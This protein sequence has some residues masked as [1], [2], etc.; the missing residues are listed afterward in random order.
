[1]NKI[2]VISTKYADAFS[3]DLNKY[4]QEGYKIKDSGFNSGI[5]YAIMIKKEKSN[6]PKDRYISNPNLMKKM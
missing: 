5:Y 3:Q 4:S 2:K 1:M 6:D